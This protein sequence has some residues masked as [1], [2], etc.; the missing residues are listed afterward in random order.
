M[1]MKGGQEVLEV[2]LH[3][4]Q[5]LALGPEPQHEPSLLS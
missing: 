5:C 1:S 2:Q 4:P 3:S